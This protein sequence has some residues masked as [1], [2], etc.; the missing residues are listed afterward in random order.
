MKP[1]Y[2]YKISENKLNQKICFLIFHYYGNFY[3]NKV[4]SVKSPVFIF[5]TKMEA[6]EFN[7]VLC[8]TLF[9]KIRLIFLACFKKGKFNQVLANL[10]GNE[11]RSCRA[12][13]Y[14]RMLL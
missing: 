13:T 7:L 10:I 1:I 6:V 4:L 8:T 12:F 9:S 3:K 14:A 11:K 2:D 5:F